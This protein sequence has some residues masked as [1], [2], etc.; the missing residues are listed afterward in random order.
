MAAQ[1]DDGGRSSHGWCA[2]Q[3]LL[4]CRVVKPIDRQQQ[5]RLRRISAIDD[6]AF[7]R[8]DGAEGATH[9]TA[10]T[11][12]AGCTRYA[13]GSDTQSS[14]KVAYRTRSSYVG[15][16]T[17]GPIR[18]SSITILEVDSGSANEHLTNTYINLSP[19]RLACPCLPTMMWSCTEIPSGLAMSTIALVMSMS[20][21]DGV[22][23]PDG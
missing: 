21:R 3:S 18:S 6:A 12:M 9:H 13:Q 5:S 22:G 20:A 2:L 17:P 15:R 19:F 23:S 7:C 10:R 16:A 14:G 4:P 1:R 11:G 8:A